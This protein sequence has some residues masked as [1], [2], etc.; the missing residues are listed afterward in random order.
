MLNKTKYC[1]LLR[2]LRMDKNAGENL[3]HKLRNRGM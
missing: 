1:F 3:L 2:F